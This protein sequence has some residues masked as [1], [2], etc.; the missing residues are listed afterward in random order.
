[1]K[2]LKPIFKILSL[3]LVIV[4]LFAF[5]ADVSDNLI[6][7]FPFNQNFNDS[8]STNDAVAFGDPHFTTDRFNTENTAIKLDGIDDYLLLPVGKYKY[9]AISLWFYVE[10]VYYSTI[11]VDYGSK[12]IFS[13]VDIFVGATP[14]VYKIKYNTQTNELLK[15]Q[16]NYDFYTW[17]H[18]YLDV[19]KIGQKPIMYIDGVFEREASLSGLCSPTTANVYIGRTSETDTSKHKFLQ[20]KVDDIYIFDYPLKQEEILQLYYHDPYS[21][22]SMTNSKIFI[23]PNPVTNVL[24]IANSINNESFRIFNSQGKVILEGKYKSEINISDFSS[25]LYFIE[26]VSGTNSFRQIYK[27]VKR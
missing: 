24:R 21:V 12:E 13:T 25:G 7:Y 27:F 16:Y 8:I 3:F 19:G 26:I 20:G 4:L 22:L 9:F 15:S 14:P 2:L 18:L 11:I 10:S 23:F 1:M 5:R 6:S 17:H